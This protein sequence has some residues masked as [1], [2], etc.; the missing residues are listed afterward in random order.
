MFSILRFDLG[1]L[2]LQSWVECVWTLWYL[3][4]SR[5]SV[6]FRQIFTLGYIHSPADRVS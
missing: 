5:A 2:I 3:L 4:G 1:F 6:G